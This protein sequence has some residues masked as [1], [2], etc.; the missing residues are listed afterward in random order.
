MDFGPKCLKEYN[1][2]HV[3]K[4]LNEVREVGKPKEILTET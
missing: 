1:L 2:V 4:K 3:I